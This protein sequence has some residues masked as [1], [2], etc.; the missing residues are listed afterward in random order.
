MA[1]D[2]TSDD[3]NRQQ[4]ARGQRV[5][6]DYHAKAHPWR[7]WMKLLSIMAPLIGGG[8]LAAFALT[9]NESIYTPGPVSTKHAIFGHRCVDCH[10]V[11]MRDGKQ[12]YGAV[13]DAKCITCHDGPLHSGRQVFHGNNKLTA[14]VDLIKTVD[15]KEVVVKEKI[16]VG[17]P[18]CAS[19]HTEHK[20][21]AQLARIDDQHCTQC[22]E[23]LQV[24]ESIKLASLK[25]RGA[26]KTRTGIKSFN[27][28]HPNWHVLESG[29]KSQIMFNHSVHIAEPKQLKGDAAVAFGR[30][31]GSTLT[32]TDCHKPDR[33]R[34]YMEPVTYNKHCA[35]C[36]T[37]SFPSSVNITAAVPHGRAD[38]VAAMIKETVSDALLQNGGKPPKKKVKKRVAGKEKVV[39]EDD[40]TPPEEWRNNA[41]T[42]STKPLMDACLKC[43]IIDKDKPKDDKGLP[44]IVDPKLPAI[45]LTS[46]IFDHE[47]HRV[48]SCESC[49]DKASA[50]K[51]TSD[52]LLPGINNC[53]TCHKESG[54]ARNG[55]SECHV[56]HDKQR[57]SP[58]STLPLDFLLNGIPPSK[59]TGDKG[60][61]KPTDKP[62]ESPKGTEEPKATDAGTK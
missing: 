24:D 4:K 59:T 16:E 50:S 41:I 62:S 13:T 28:G 54:G 9:K 10:E 39:E 2:V 34:A 51:L 42:Q 37:L 6:H 44:N 58:P 25:D 38:L 57:K 47:P 31:E 49:H 29:D 55:C 26:R 5:D 14:E 36:H 8:V 20:G 11:G 30:A 61:D 40:P 21:H 45:F 33:Y 52:V 35:S 23:N 3:P 17:N 15:G 32:C 22:H 7:T 48:V 19:C 12:Y 53:Q 46:A 56:Y 43:H 27:N 60:T 18:T 1:R